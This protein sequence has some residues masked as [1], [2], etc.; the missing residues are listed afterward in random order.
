MF[1]FDFQKMSVVDT[2]TGKK[3]ELKRTE[4]GPLNSPKINFLDDV[5][6]VASDAHVGLV[7]PNWN[8]YGSETPTT[9]K[10]FDIGIIFKA[11]TAFMTGVCVFEKDPS[12]VFFGLFYPYF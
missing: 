5:I 8:F 4:Y 11:E 2:K 3:F 12:V 7:F 6:L 9:A 10:F 1:N